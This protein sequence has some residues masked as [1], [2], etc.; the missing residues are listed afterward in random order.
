MR[1]V[2]NRTRASER[3]SAGAV[4]KPQAEFPTA[5]TRRHASPRVPLP[6]HPTA[7]PPPRCAAP[8]RAVPCR[9]ATPIHHKCNQIVL[10]AITIRSTPFPSPGRVRSRHPL[11]PSARAT[12]ARNS[13]P[14]LVA[15]CEI[16]E[17][18][19]FKR[20]LDKVAPGL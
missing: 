18:C 15:P 17:G 7:A 2:G 9:A 11:S 20:V 8:R 16:C 19:S 12:R 6:T 4:I 5:P 10:R 1:G 13:P 3:A 14:G